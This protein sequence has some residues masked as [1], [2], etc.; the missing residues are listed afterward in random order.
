MWWICKAV[1]QLGLSPPSGVTAKG[2]AAQLPSRCGSGYR[3]RPEGWGRPARPR[4]PE[5]CA[6][7]A[8]GCPARRGG[9]QG[10]T[11]APLPG[12]SPDVRGSCRLP[13]LPR[14]APFFPESAGSGAGSDGGREGRKSAYDSS[15]HHV[16]SV[17]QPSS[18]GF[19]AGGPQT[20]SQKHS[21]H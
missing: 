14:P 19:G 5:G 2:C 20:G 16:T 15:L 3:Q 9:R 17:E 18:T 10:G 13:A 11:S 6:G 8:L 12:H 4:T 1:H 21:G 7:I